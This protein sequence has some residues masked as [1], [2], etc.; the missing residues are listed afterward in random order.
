L[1]SKKKSLTERTKR[2]E[3]DIETLT[4]KKQ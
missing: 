3:E 4:L 2:L 1:K